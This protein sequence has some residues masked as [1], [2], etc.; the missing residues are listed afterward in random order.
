MNQSIVFDDYNTEIV[1]YQIQLHQ[2]YYLFIKSSFDYTYIKYII[3]YQLVFL[4][5]INFK[6]TH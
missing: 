2:I 4:L 3:F 1:L 5:Q 6:K